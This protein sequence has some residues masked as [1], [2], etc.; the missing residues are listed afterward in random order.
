[1]RVFDTRVHDPAMRLSEHFTLK[2]FQCND[3]S[4]IVLVHFLLPQLLEQIR[5]R[6]GAPIQITSAFR[7]PSH[8]RAIGG[9]EHSY[10]LSGFAADI[11]SKA[12]TPSRIAEVAASL[13]AGGVAAYSSFCHVDMGRKRTWSTYA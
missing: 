3:G 4:P 7:T 10:H 5:E 13:G 9:A 1:M 11:S 2:E 8:N 6:I 12:A